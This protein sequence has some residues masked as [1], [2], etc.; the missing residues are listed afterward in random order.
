MSFGFS[1]KN[2]NIQTSSTTTKKK[3]KKKELKTHKA[4]MHVINKRLS[5]SYLT[6]SIFENHTNRKCVLN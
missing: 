4:N 6:F 1:F 5:F 3:E 2:F